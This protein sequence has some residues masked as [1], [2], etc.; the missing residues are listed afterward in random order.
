MCCISFFSAGVV[1]GGQHL[2]SSGRSKSITH[3]LGSDHQRFAS[4][5]PLEWLGQ[6]F[7][8]VGDEAVDFVFEVLGRGEGSAAQNLAGEDGEPEFDLVEPRGMLWRKMEADAVIGIAQEGFPSRAAMATKGGD[9]ATSSLEG[10]QPG[11]MR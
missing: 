5:G 1:G 8:E 10:Q 6:D 7:I 2:A 3:R 4:H 9:I 11:S